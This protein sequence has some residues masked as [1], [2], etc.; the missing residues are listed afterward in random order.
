MEP[1][2][3]NFRRNINILDLL[4]REIYNKP[5]TNSNN[6]ENRFKFNSDL[7]SYQFNQNDTGDIQPIE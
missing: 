6:N 1:R 4:N 3:V 2:Q 7:E 5:N